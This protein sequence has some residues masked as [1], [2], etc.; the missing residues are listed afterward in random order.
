MDNPV[1]TYDVLAV[2][3]HPDDIEVGCGGVILQLTERGHRVG[4]VILTQGEM[5]T[6]GTAE[7]RQQELGAAARI[8]GADVIRQFDW[9]DTRLEDSYEHRLDLA[10]IIRATRPKLILCPYPEVA[11]G[12]RQSHADH[13]ASGV[14]TINAA[15]L[16]TLIKAPI[17]GER[18]LV[19]RIF[20]YFL[21]PGVAPTF[22]VDITEQYEKWIQA[23][24]AHQSQFMN[25]AKSRDYVEGLTTMART[26]GALARVKY[27]QGFISVEPPVVRDITT[28]VDPF[29]D[30][31]KILG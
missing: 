11:H 18:H 21:P 23:L 10:R 20:H 3:A 30:Q 16:A 31:G 29:N 22:V 25:P 2:G 19:E 13:V 17:D 12:R 28:L 15:N 14:I 24:V 8:M 4:L 6:G 27:G 9:G 1:R 5:G 26:F 7:I